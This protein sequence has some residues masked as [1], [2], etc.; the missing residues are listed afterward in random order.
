M[1]PIYSLVH[2]VLCI[3]LNTSRTNIMGS[4][5]SEKSTNI[6]RGMEIK[7]SNNIMGS[8]RKEKKEKNERYFK[9]KWI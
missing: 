5:K 8:K 7:Q 1:Q 4:K 9:N 3:E 6:I 2:F